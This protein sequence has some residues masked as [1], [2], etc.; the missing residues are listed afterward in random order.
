[1]DI[2]HISVSRKSVID[3]CDQSYKYKY[4]LRLTSPEPEPFYFVYGKIIHKIAEDY[5]EGKGDKVL[6]EVALD[7]LEGRIPLERDATTPVYAPSLPVEYRKRMPNHLISLKKI[8]DQIGFEG[9]LEYPF[10]EDLDPPNGKFLKGFIDR[11]VKK[12]DL[13][14]ILD[15]KTTK[16]G[17]WRK[18]TTTIKH[19]L[20]LRAYAKIVQKHFDVPA[21]KIRCAL[22]YLEDAQLIA[23]QYDQ[24]SIDHSFVELLEAYNYIKELPPDKTVGNVGDHCYRC[25]FRKICPFFNMI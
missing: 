25:D 11:L 2:E 1:M 16:K 22:Y 14:F 10:Y 21:E 7:V 24:E 12:D 5:V 4:H 19:D 15:Y 18:D 17:K 8:T 6:S 20:Q 13:W 23:A 3:Q 9:Q